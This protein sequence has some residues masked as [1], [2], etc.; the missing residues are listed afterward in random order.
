MKDW[1][2]LRERI[3]IIKDHFYSHRELS[4]A[5]RRTDDKM[6]FLL[7]NF[8]D[9]HALR[10]ATGMLRLKQEAGFQML[11]I[12]TAL[13]KSQNISFW[14]AYGTLL[15]AVRH[16]G[17]V[18]WDDDVD[19]GTLL[20]DYELLFAILKSEMPNRFSV[21]KWKDDHGNDIGIM[22]IVDQISRCHVDIYPFEQVPGA[23]K[24]DGMKTL[25]EKSYL[26]KFAYFSQRAYLHGLSDA[27]KRD[28]DIWR[29]AHKTGDGNVNGIAVS[30]YFTSAFKRIV[31]KESDL[32]PL[33]TAVFE[34]CSFPVPSNPDAILSRIYGDYEMFPSDVGHSL[35]GHANSSDMSLIEMRKTVDDLCMLAK[36]LEAS[37][38][39]IV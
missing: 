8:L 33:G 27:L 18:P 9:I 11:R 12:V 15:G 4:E 5:L 26:E 7:N 38:K 24:C 14:L 35:H 25:W 37:L 32:F 20:P 19:I 31:C 3:R 29:E 39:T 28:I 30:M 36:S 34:G 2:R 10:P 16:K 1:F 22:R 21:A 17:F 6:I 13:A 23:L